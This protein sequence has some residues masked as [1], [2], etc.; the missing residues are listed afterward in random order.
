MLA[1]HCNL[2]SSNGPNFH[3][4]W[5]QLLMLCLHQ[6]PINAAAFGFVFVDGGGGQSM[7]IFDGFLRQWLESANSSK[8]CVCDRSKSSSTPESPVLLEYS[9]L[10]AV[11]PFLSW[12]V[13]NVR[14][15]SS[16]LKKNKMPLVCVNWYTAAVETGWTNP[17]FYLVDLFSEWS[18]L[19]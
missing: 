5:T 2:A 9:A 17:K 10:T 16:C 8:V 6:K 18:T 3:R 19:L 13:I 1:R 15:G 14:S 7:R 11:N 12:A 4:K